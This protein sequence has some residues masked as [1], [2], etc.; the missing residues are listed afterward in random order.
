MYFKN[1]PIVDSCWYCGC[2]LYLSHSSHIEGSK[3]T[4]RKFY[5]LVDR[6][7]QG[8]C[9]VSRPFA[10]NCEWQDHEPIMGRVGEPFDSDRVDRCVTVKGRT[11]LDRANRYVVA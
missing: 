8:T 4:G 6:H 5:G 9:Y 3:I 11:L 2:D 7:G 10:P 1:A